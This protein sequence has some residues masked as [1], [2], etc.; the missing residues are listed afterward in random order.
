ML[1][2][3]GFSRP[4]VEHSMLSCLECTIAGACPET[5][6]W[7]K[8][9]LISYIRL[10]ARPGQKQQD[11]IFQTPEHIPG[12]EGMIKLCLDG[13][14]AAD[15]LLR[16]CLPFTFTVCEELSLP[17]LTAEIVLRRIFT[18]NELNTLKA[19]FTIFRNY[20]F[21]TFQI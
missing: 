4:Q 19:N 9:L 3:S 21:L 16:C 14:D 15:T 18:R 20:K 6:N 12:E 11:K 7:I 5:R 10:V 17:I 1:S 13:R 8:T 2:L